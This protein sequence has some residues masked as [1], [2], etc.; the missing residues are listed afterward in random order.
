VQGDSHPERQYKMYDPDLYA[1]TMRNVAKDHP[2]FYVA[3][4][5]DFS[6][7]RLI[8]DKTVGQENVDQVYARQQLDGVVYQS[9]P[10]PADPTYEAFNR[11]AYNSGDILPNSGYLRIMV[12][13]EEVRV[14]YVRS[15]LP[16]DER[17]GRMNDDMGHSYVIRNKSK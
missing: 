8:S 9:A 7:E 15:F 14:E 4:G 2:D 12:S 5:D 16:P 13:H 1:L 11:D 10:N 6:I 17:E 3:L